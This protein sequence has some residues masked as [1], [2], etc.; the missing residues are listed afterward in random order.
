MMPE[1]F[2]ISSRL[3]ACDS[4]D[5]AASDSDT[6]IQRLECM[7]EGKVFGF[8]EYYEFGGICI[9]THTEITLV[10]QGQ[11]YGS[12]VARQAMKHFHKHGKRVVPICG[13]IAH[14]LRK[15]L[16][17]LD[18]VTPESQHIFNIENKS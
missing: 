6:N 11:G 13:F 4:M 16:Q 12:R 2:S 17:Y 7:E 18:L 5:S 8:V 3:Y 10:T 14:Y 1:Q 15:N 9:I